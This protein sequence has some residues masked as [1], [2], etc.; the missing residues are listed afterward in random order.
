MNATDDK[1]GGDM[2]PSQESMLEL[3]SI[4]DEHRAAVSS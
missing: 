2:P 1:V 3:M 4:V